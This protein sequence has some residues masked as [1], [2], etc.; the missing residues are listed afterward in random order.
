MNLEVFD[1]WYQHTTRP[2][3]SLAIYT[4]SFNTDRAT[5]IIFEFPVSAKIYC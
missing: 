5:R 2:F 4:E 1:S 3:D